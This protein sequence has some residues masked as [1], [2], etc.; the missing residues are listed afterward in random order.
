M[1]DDVDFLLNNFNN[2]N[3]INSKRFLV[4]LKN[5][6][7]RFFGSEPILMSVNTERFVFAVNR[8]EQINSLFTEKLKNDSFSC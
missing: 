4:Y 3:D 5:N 6:F 1:I 7:N 8:S 2:Q